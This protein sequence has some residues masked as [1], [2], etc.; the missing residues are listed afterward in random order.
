M[1]E[2]VLIK[3]IIIVISD[4]IKEIYNYLYQDSAIFLSRKKI[5][6]EKYIEYRANSITNNIEQCNA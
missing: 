6:F 4:K 5:K 1:K 3:K 2:I